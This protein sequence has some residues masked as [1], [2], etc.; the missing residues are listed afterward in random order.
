MQNRKLDWLLSG[1]STVDH[2]S[3]PAQDNDSA[4][5]LHTLIASSYAHKLVLVT[6]GARSKLLSHKSFILWEIINFWR[7]DTRKP[8]LSAKYHQLRHQAQSSRENAPRSLYA[9]CSKL[10][11]HLKSVHSQCTPL[12]HAFDE[13]GTYQSLAFCGLGRFAEVSGSQ[14]LTFPFV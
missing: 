10:H 7:F 4:N 9:P 14:L 12:G 6:R 3:F 8:S 11:L 2:L 1:G 5:T 13:W